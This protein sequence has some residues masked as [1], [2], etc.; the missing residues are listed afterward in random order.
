MWDEKGEEFQDRKK[1]PKERDGLK[2]VEML[3]VGAS[4][5][6]KSFNYRTLL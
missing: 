5:E 6:F 4:L 2:I 1:G 3:L